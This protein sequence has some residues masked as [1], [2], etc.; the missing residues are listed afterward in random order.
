MVNLYSF[1]LDCFILTKITGNLP[2]FEIN[3]EA[4]NI[5]AYIELAGQKSDE[6]Q[7][8]DLL[9]EADIFW[10]ILRPEKIK[11]ANTDLF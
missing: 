10:S 1:N 4:L 9:I 3:H 6:S 2:G 7:Q 5:P 11:L 8:F